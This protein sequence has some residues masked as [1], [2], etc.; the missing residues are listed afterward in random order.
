MRGKRAKQIRRLADQ[1]T[2]GMTK[3][4]Y[5]D[6]ALNKSKPTRRTR[7]L[8]ECTRQVYRTLKARYKAGTWK[9]RIV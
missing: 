8:Y 7:Q 3:R 5:Q 2:I 9:A 6:I 4:Q 1:I